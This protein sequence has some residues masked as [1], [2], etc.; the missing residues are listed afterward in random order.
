MAEDLEEDVQNRCVERGIQLGMDIQRE[1]DLSPQSSG[2]PGSGYDIGASSGYMDRS[3]MTPTRSLIDSPQ[4]RNRLVTIIGL[5]P[6]MQTSNPEVSEVERARLLSL[7]M[8]M[9]EPNPNPNPNPN[10]FTLT[11]NGHGGRK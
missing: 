4:N 11:T 10:P 7:L 3:P 8:D 9:E 6:A 1:M 2:S 5:P